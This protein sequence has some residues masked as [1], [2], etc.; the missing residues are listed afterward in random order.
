MRMRLDQ[1]TLVMP[2]GICMGLL[3]ILVTFIDNV[4]VASPFSDLVG[5]FR[6]RG[7]WWCL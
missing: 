6:E 1:A 2:L 3:M 5:R 7:F 4:W